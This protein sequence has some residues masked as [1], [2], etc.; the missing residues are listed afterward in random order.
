[1]KWYD[2]HCKRPGLFQQSL[3]NPVAVRKHTFQDTEG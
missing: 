2:V 3:V 1:M